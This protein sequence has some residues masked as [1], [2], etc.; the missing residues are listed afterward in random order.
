MSSYH[1][2]CV[3]KRNFSWS[4]RLL[5]EHH[6]CNF[7]CSRQASVNQERSGFP[8][9][10]MILPAICPRDPHKHPFLTDMTSRCV[11]FNAMNDVKRTGSHSESHHL[12]WE[13]HICTSAEEKVPV[14]VSQV[15]LAQDRHVLD[16]SS[17]CQSLHER[18]N[19]QSNACKSCP[20]RRAR[21]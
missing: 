20:A 2:T 5:S 4:G 15:F 18:L 7:D 17:G 6:G 10:Q 12:S 19:I 21:Q 1:V 14:V 13:S 16:C 3:R 9:L 8:R 11:T